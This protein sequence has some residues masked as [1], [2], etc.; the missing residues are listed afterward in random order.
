MVDACARVLRLFWDQRSRYD[1]R[2]G[3]LVFVRR[4][5]CAIDEDELG[6]ASLRESSCNCSYPHGYYG[7]GRTAP[8]GD[9]E[10][11]AIIQK[12]GQVA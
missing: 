2:L 12:E 1:R 4:R 10:F 6:L 7:D 5:T 11:R 8:H 3:D 9:A